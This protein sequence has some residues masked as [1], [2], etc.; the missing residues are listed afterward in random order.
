[1]KYASKIIYEF[2]DK[3]ESQARQ[4]VATSTIFGV[5]VGLLLAGIAY[6]LIHGR[7]DGWIF[8]L[9]MVIPTFMGYQNG[10]RKAFQLRLEAQRALCLVQIEENTRQSS[11][12]V[13][14]N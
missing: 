12:M 9:L 10:R 3:L 14:K 6:N 5:L 7:A 2:A 1:M 11:A 4:A 13:S 8:G